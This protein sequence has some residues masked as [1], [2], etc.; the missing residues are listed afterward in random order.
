MGTDTDRPDLGPGF[1]V[2]AVDE[3]LAALA[4]CSRSTPQ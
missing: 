1:A 4:P 3:W 2:D